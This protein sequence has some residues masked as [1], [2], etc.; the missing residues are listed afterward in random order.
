M[1]SINIENQKFGYLTALF[2]IESNNGRVYKCRCDC[3]EE[4]DFTTSFLMKSKKKN[5][6]FMPINDNRIVI[7]DIN[8]RIKYNMDVLSFISNKD[9]YKFIQYFAYKQNSFNLLKDSIEKE[10]MYV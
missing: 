9:K 4:R 3:G 10:L 7:S 6:K 2:P 8:R 1:R 5:I